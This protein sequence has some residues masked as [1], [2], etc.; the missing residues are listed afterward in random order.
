MPTSTSDREAHDRPLVF[1]GVHLAVPDIAKANLYLFATFGFIRNSL[2][3]K[4][5]FDESLRA[6]T[7]NE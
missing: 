3:S 1:I 6:P 7:V 4:A 5:P 2:G